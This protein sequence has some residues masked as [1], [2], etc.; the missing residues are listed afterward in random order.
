MSMKEKSK[1]KDG[2]FSYGDVEFTEDEYKEAQNPKVRTTM[3]LEEDL[4]RAY[5]AEALARGMKYQQLMR[6]KLREALK[7]SSVEERLQKI[8]DTLYS[9]KKQA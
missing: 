5:K 8:E 7:V 1:L 3:F 2:E 9:K 4:I 6:E